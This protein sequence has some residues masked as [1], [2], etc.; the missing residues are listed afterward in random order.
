MKR[1]FNYTGRIR[2]TRSEAQVRILEDE[3]EGSPV[4]QLDLNIRPNRQ[5]PPDAVVRVEA[6]RSNVSQSWDYGTV[7][8]LAT[9]SAN[10]RRLTDVE[11][12]AQFKVFVVASDGSGRLLGLADR[13]R[14][15]QPIDS[16]V[17]LKEVG[18]ETLGEEVWRVDFGTEG[19]DGPVLLVN[20]AIP[21]IADVVQGNDTFRTLIMPQV[22]RIILTHIAI[23]ERHEPDDNEESWWTDWF[24]FARNLEAGPPNDIT[25]GDNAAE[26]DISEMQLWIHG[27]VK[28]FTD[29]RLHAVSQFTSE[30]ERSRS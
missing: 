17:P 6:A 20:N 18:R 19:E 26:S 2:I 27:V 8:Q 10:E 24:Q 9:L 4:F 12:T 14:P 16:L 21:G 22:L 30:L 25:W 11:R 15:I 23:I 29:R 3:V 1:H 5:F 13:I 7:A 28:A